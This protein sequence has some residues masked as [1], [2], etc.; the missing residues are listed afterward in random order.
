M[1]RQPITNFRFLRRKIEQWREEQQYSITVR[2]L[3][4]EREKL[5]IM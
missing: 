4:P 1:K 5:K 3:E 2:V